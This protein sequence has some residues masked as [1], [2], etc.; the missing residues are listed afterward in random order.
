M[1]NLQY[2]QRKE[3]GVSLHQKEFDKQQTSK[4]SRVSM[5]S[6]SVSLLETNL[7]CKHDKG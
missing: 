3:Q 5:S 1:L 6:L 7:V 2:K 4:I